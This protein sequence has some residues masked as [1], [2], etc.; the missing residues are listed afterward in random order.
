MSI[1]AL[2]KVT[3]YG[4][5]ADVPR[6]LDSLQDFGRMHLVP[7]AEGAELEPEE[8]AIAR[9]RGAREALRHLLDAPTKRKQSSY[10]EAFDLGD[11]VARSVD[12]RRKK[13]ALQERIDGL[14]AR[15]AEVEPWGSFELPPVE[16]LSGNRLWFYVV[17]HHLLRQ[18]DPGDLAWQIV[19]RDNRH[20]F[21]ALVSPTQPPAEAMPVPRA[22]LG[23]RS[24]RALR[25]DLEE[26]EAEM[27]DL[28]IERWSLT[29]WISLLIRNLA[30]A[31]DETA[32]TRAREQALDAGEVFAVKGWVPARDIERLVEFARDEGLACTHA[33]P[34]PEDTPPVLLEN[35]PAVAP[36]EDLVGFYQLPGYGDWDPSPVVYVS[37]ALFF[38]M[39]IADAA[40]GAVLGLIAFLLWK[41]MGESASGRRGRRMFAFVSVACVV[42]GVMVGS[43][44]GLT[45]PE[46]TVLGRLQ[47]LD[48]TD[49]GSMMPISI[50]IGVLQLALANLVHAWGRLGSW[51][52]LAPVGWALAMLGGF[53]VYVGFAQA[54]VAA[55][56][57]GLALVFLFTSERPIRRALDVPMRVVDGVMALTGVSKAF[58]DILSYLRL[59]ALGLSSASLALTFNQLG[60][61]IMG[62]G[63]GIAL[64]LGL[65]VLV[66]GHGL[67]FILGIVS[68]VV[69]GL[70]LNVIELYNWSVFGEGVPFQAFARQSVQAR[71]GGDG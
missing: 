45:P 19:H 49:F 14:S 1:I 50:G 48:A 6:V 70:R 12:N 10:E 64:L 56:G 62:E 9:S 7:L 27:E 21:V 8:K 61:D 44:F 57:V 22:R 42:Y 23:K 66:L 28:Q 3:L 39:I 52:A 41:R 69:H 37:F 18:M 40:Y 13:R 17:P 30:R 11:V 63:K 58:G 68:G 38:A 54:G 5:S 24:L 25:R 65:M 33:D 53:A 59:F 43:Y 15:I 46:G 20:A 51:A 71:D 55:L 47:V 34:G 36:G 2:K 32:R 16:D 67:N 35:A 26:A 4:A 29:R 60:T 31:D